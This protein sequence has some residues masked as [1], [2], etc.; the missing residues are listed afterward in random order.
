MSQ[1]GKKPEC[2]C[3]TGVRGG[4]T[5]LTLFIASIHRHEHDKVQLDQGQLVNGTCKVKS[6]VTVL[7]DTK[8]NSSCHFSPDRAGANL[9]LGT[10]PRWYQLPTFRHKAQRCHDLHAPMSTE[11]NTRNFFDRCIILLLKS[12]WQITHCY[13]KKVEIGGNNLKNV[14]FTKKIG[15]FC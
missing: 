2:F 5:R 15:D 11:V 8:S 4:R 1:V 6:L 12:N 13:S 9:C 3:W 7:Q 14:G 10:F